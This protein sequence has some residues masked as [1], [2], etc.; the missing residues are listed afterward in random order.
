LGARENS[1]YLDVKYR[2]NFTEIHIFSEQ[3]SYI[4]HDEISSR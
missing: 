1:L 4:S 2:E 3:P